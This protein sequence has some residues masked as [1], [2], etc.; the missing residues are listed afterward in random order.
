VTFVVI[1]L[2]ALVIGAIMINDGRAYFSNFDEHTF[3]PNQLDLQELALVFKN[4]GGI[5]AGMFCFS[6]VLAIVF[7]LLIKKFTQCMVYSMIILIFLVYAAL[8][9]FGII[10]K[11]WWMVVVFVIVFAVTALLLCCFWSK[12]QTGIM[13]L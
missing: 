13:L 3:D 4:H 10:N 8:I 6:L 11:I 7:L 1:V 12:L 9:V 5:I 2:A